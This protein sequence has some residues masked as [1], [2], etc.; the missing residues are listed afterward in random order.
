MVTQELYH[1]EAVG[2]NGTLRVNG[3]GIGGFICTVSGTITITS[4]TGST[5]FVNAFPVTAGTIY[6]LALYFGVNGGNVTLA[7]GAAGTVLKA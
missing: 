1:G 2:V 7:G 4:N 6:G 3:Q 5:T